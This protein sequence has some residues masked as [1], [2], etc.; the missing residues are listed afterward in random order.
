M[1][2][3]EMKNISSSSEIKEMQIIYLMADRNG[4]D[5]VSSDLEQVKENFSEGQSADSYKT[6]ASER[7][8]IEQ[9]SSKR[10][11]AHAGP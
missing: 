11:F 7:Q 2:I 6:V 9:K 5:S 3:F 1:A 10:E 8:G 4:S